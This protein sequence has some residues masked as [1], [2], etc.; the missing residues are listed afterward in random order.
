MSPSEVLQLRKKTGLIT[1]N[2][3]GKGHALDVP[4]GQQLSKLLKGRSEEA[5]DEDVGINLF[6]NI[7]MYSSRTFGQGS[8]WEGD[9]FCHA[10][11]VRCRGCTG[12][13]RHGRLRR[14]GIT[15]LALIHLPIASAVTALLA[16][17]LEG[18]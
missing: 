12:L 6:S 2:V 8:G 5:I 1:K 7:A 17:R 18:P 11:L 13:G 3:K 15:V 9:S 16:W 14:F 4:G 10:T